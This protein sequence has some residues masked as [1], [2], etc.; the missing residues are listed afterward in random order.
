MKP[1]ICSL[2]QRLYNLLMQ[3]DFS[4]FTMTRVRDA[5]AECI[6]D[7]DFEISDLRKYLYSHVK[8]MIKNGWV[9]RDSVRRQRGQVYHV[10]E[11]PS[12][13]RVKLISPG[14]E[15]KLGAMTGAMD[16]SFLDGPDGEPKQGFTQIALLE[17]Q[18]KETRLDM[19]SS[20]GEAEK[21]K[22]LMEELPQLANTLKAEYLEARN[23]SS[24]LLGQL[25]ALEKTLQAL[26]GSS[27]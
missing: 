20:L 4:T 12:D 7:F 27:P 26:H 18:H 22:S 6:H 2:D 11:K 1:R 3:K 16:V 17:A 5:Y 21:Y 14:F 10:L 8:R 19:L 13:L 25:R 24:R 9:E 15:A 23:R